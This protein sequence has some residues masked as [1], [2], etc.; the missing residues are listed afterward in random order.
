MSDTV[1]LTVGELLAILAIV[2]AHG[3]TQSRDR[4]AARI[5]AHIDHQEVT[6]ERHR[7]S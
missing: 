4:L 7:P 2:I 3:P 5:R 1:P 6:H